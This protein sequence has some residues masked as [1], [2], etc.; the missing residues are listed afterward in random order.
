MGFN[1]F[2]YL[3][4]SLAMSKVRSHSEDRMRTHLMHRHKIK[5][6]GTGLRR[7]PHR[8]LYERY[9]LYKVSTGAGWRSAHA[10]A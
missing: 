5:D 7:F 8:D 6:R 10:S 2:H 4:S 9:G 1:Y 3:N